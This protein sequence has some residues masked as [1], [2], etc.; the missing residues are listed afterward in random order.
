MAAEQM[1]MIHR[2]NPLE[3]G[4]ELPN[5]NATPSIA[6]DMNFWPSCAPCKNESATAQ[7]SWITMKRRLALSRLTLRNN[8]SMS[9]VKIHPRMKPA[10]SENT[11]P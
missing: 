5:D 3:S 10:T 7:R 9:F 11:M 4:V 1:I 8:S 6:I 2:G